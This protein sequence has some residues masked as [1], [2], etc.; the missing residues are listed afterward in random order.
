VRDEE[1]K[2][3]P[4]WFLILAVVFLGLVVMLVDAVIQWIL[5]DR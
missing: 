4:R 5:P 1:E 3:P 2:Q